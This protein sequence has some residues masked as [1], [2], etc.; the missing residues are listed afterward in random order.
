MMGDAT[1]APAAI[2]DFPFGVLVY[3]DDRKANWLLAQS[4]RRLARSGYRLGGVV[5]SDARRSGRGKCDMRLTDLLSGERVQISYDL[6]EEARG[7]RLDPA[8]FAHAGVLIERALA[9]DIDLLI[10]NKFGKQEAEGRGFRSVIAEALLSN[11]PVA[12]AVSRRNLDACLEFAGG[13]FAH[14][15]P[16]QT[17]I[18]AWCRRA[19][20]RTA[21]ARR[22]TQPFREAR[23]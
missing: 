19:I 10:I 18:V 12:L 6:G 4:A 9:A 1:D 22:V 8:A 16:S 13:S 2:G 11:I 3:D 17:G 15:A 20:R 23:D 5:Q 21:D 7:C 14:L